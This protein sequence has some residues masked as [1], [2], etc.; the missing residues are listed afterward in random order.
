MMVLVHS[1]VRLGAVFGDAEVV[2]N[3]SSSGDAATSCPLSAREGLISGVLTAGDEASEGVWLL[4]EVALL[5]SWALFSLLLESLAAACLF[6]AADIPPFS[7]ACFLSFLLGIQPVLAPRL[8]AV[9]RFAGRS[10]KKKETRNNKESRAEPS[11]KTIQL[12]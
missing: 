7:L 3:A 4:L 11:Q 10:K 12:Q 6:T 5:P 8:E 2:D 1:L 9:S